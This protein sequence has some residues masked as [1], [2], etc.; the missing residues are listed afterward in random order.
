MSA[1]CAIL[2]GGMGTRLGALTRETPKPLL[3]VAGEPF[4]DVL[5]R[6]AVRRGFRDLVLLAG[7]KAEIVEDYASQLRGRL[8]ADC[9]VSVSVEPEPLG[10]GGALVHAKDLLADRF[11]LLNGDTWFDF[12][13][14]DLV[15]LAGTEAAVAARRIVGTERYET[16]SLDPDGRATAVLPRGLGSPSGLV[17]G[18]VYVLRKQDL[19]GLPSH[20]SVESDLLP[21]LINRGH[22]RGRE[23]DGFFIDIGIPETFEAAQVEIPRRRCRPAVFF[24]RDGV[25]N[26]D[27]NYVGSI[28]RFRWMAGAKHAIKLAYDLGFY[29]FVVSNQAGVARGF[30]AE[31]DVEALHRWMSDELRKEGASVD[32]WRFCPFHPDATVDAYKGSH[33]W[34]KPNPGMLA[35]LIR[36][37]PVDVEGSILIGDQP[38][39]LAAATA[40]GVTPFLFEGG[41]LCQ[42]FTEILADRK[43]KSVEWTS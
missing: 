15:S 17:N 27:D 8:P 10:T 31:T 5:V 9:L 26:H 33:A 43:E 3:D 35:D 25:L 29:V 7:F 11:L 41:D 32:D 1:Q 36:H 34:R 19:A 40:A 21:L 18:G 22:L 28:D 30:Y 23:Y 38:S 12:N 4:L 14:L 6:E 16:L 13:W 20:C 24:D 37:W 42:R 2:L 39:D